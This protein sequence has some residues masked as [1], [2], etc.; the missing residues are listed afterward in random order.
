MFIYIHNRHSYN[1]ILRTNNKHRNYNLRIKPALVGDCF[2]RVIYIYERNFRY[3]T[4]FYKHEFI[5]ITRNIIYFCIFRNYSQ[6]D[7]FPT[8]ASKLH[9]KPLFSRMNN[10]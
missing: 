7:H 8:F 4:I 3:G 1:S 9:A 5:S 2:P 10:F 6:H